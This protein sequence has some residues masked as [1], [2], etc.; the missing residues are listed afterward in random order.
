MH[1]AWWRLTA[2]G[3]VAGGV[4]SKP[5]PLNSPAWLPSSCWDCRMTSEPSRAGASPSL[6]YEP[7]MQVQRRA[8]E[9]VQSAHATRERASAI[10]SSAKAARTRAQA[11]RQHSL[12]KALA[13]H[14]G[15]DYR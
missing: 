9:A 6:T 5:E 7:I 4:A 10:R 8:R 11:L 1:T 12:S 14:P 2:H 13:R 3:S 15:A